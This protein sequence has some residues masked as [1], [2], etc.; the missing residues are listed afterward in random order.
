[1]KDLSFSALQQLQFIHDFPCE[2]R[3]VDSSDSP[4]WALWTELTDAGYII[5]CQ[6]YSKCGDDLIE[7]G[8]GYDITP[9]GNAYL[10]EFSKRLECQ[11]VTAIYL[12]RKEYKLLKKMRNRNNVSV[13]SSA[14]P[15]LVLA[16]VVNFKYIENHEDDG[17]CVEVCNITNTGRRYL[18]YRHEATVK[19]WA[20]IIISVLALIS[21]IALPL[22]L[23][24]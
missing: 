3:F 11:N 18:D 16:G 1:M 7:N 23:T 19:T 13:E 12:N 17:P 22:I 6:G 14:V 4:A 9:E 15:A 8:A 21:S 5:E 2:A 20:P 10:L 24:A